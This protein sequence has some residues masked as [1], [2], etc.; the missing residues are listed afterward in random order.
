M[1]P[2]RPIEY[3]FIDGGYFKKAVDVANED[4]K[5]LFGKPC[6]IDFGKLRGRHQKV[7]YYDCLPHESNKSGRK[8][9]EEFFSDLRSLPGFHVYTG[10]LRGKLP[11]LRQKKVDILIAV[12][13]LMHT[14]NKNTAK[15][16]FIAGDADFVPLIESL[17]Q[18]GAYTRLIYQ[19]KS[20][21]SELLQT[22]DEGIEI[23]MH[24][25]HGWATEHYQQAYHFPGGSITSHFNIGNSVLLKKGY[26]QKNEIALY[27]APASGYELVWNSRSDTER[28]SHTNKDV[29]LKYFEM[30]KG[31]IKW[32]D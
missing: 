31:K 10:E 28:M 22:V 7:F 12:H 15:I 11:N 4:L 9:Q 27:E 5:V 26:F 16:T 21:S 17:V 14:I 32:N 23:D 6:E 29:L 8:K 1:L 18:L 2:T 20:I 24:M 3:L 25:L 19:N 30:K 13:M